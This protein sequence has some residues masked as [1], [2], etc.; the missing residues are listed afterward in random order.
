M[1]SEEAWKILI[2]DDDADICSDVQG[3]LKRVQFGDPPLQVKVSTEL[4]VANTT[5]RLKKERYD[6]VI[7]DIFTG[8]PER[9]VDH[10][11][12]AFDE[13][14]QLRF[15]PIIFYTARPEHAQTLD[16]I[17]VKIVDKA[18]GTDALK[19]AIEEVFATKLPALIRHLEDVQRVYLW[20]DLP[21]LIRECPHPLDVGEPACLVARRL[22]Q[23]MSED[24]LRAF[25]KIEENKVHPAEL[26]VIPPPPSRLLSGDIYKQKLSAQEKYWILLTPS[27]DLVTGRH[28]RGVQ[29]LL[30]AQCFP[31]LDQPEYTKW[32]ESLKTG[33]E[34]EERTRGNLTALM[35]NNRGGKYQPERYYFLPGV[36]HVPDLVV[37]YQGLI[38]RPKSEFQSL[39]WERIAALD[40]P[41]AEEL[42][43]RFARYFGRIG[44]LDLDTELICERLKNQQ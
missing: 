35:R 23:A 37:D 5:N 22:A 19:L 20:T 2:A 32:I 41:Y 1:P 27:C 13:I 8:P 44:T 36:M 17:Y 18:E 42:L 12:Q 39:K 16:L 40:S 34:E 21:K 15:V 43:T 31:L 6:L 28:R 33:G 3:A 10:G 26:Y 14:K 25:L 30:F 9:G 4:K 11:F 38:A 24:P 29:H 7:Q